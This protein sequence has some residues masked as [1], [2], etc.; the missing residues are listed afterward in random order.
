VVF[1]IAVLSMQLEDWPTADTNLKRLLDLGYRDRNTVRFYLGQVSEEEKRFPDALK[2][3]SE[4][5]RGEQFMPAQIRSAQV[6]SKQGDL[7][8]A[9]KFLQGVNAQSNDQRVQLILAEAQLLRDAK[10]EKEAFGVVDEA[11]DKLPNN[12]EL[13]YDHAMLAEKIDRVD[14]LESS[15]RKLISIK[16]DHAHA[17]N[18]LG[19][20]LADR[21]Q[22]LEEAQELIDKALK[23]S[24]DD[25][26]IMDS[27]GWVLFRQGKTED[28]LK[29]LQRAY[30]IRPDAEIA[31]HL[32]E[33]LWVLGRRDG[34][35]GL[36][37]GAQE[38][39]RQRRPDEDR[40]AARQVARPSRARVARSAMRTHSTLLLAT[41]A[42]ALLGACVSV[43]APALRTGEFAVVGRVAVRY[44]EEAASG[45]VA[46]RHSDA[47]DERD[48][49][50]ARAGHRR[51]HAARGRVYACRG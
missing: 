44:G 24:P 14:V 17:Y 19:Y 5:T 47:D 36:G 42:T 29:Y 2:W 22:R 43:P 9:R 49:D 16:P 27:M 46:W 33:V 37:R 32:G 1:S 6:L 18:A 21:N 15:L 40:P 7:D 11:L 45:R 13:L 28:G 23:L 30:S 26:F 25:A 10:Q 3:Y 31:A 51:D 48:L 39:A 4:V 41:V 34:H 38:D 20:T 50:P 35:A 12:P 8:G